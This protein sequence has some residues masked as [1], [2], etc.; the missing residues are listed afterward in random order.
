MNCKHVQFL[1]V[2]IA[3]A[4]LSSTVIAQQYSAFKIYIMSD[5]PRIDSLLFGNH[6]NATY[7]LDT[8]PL[9]FDRDT[10]YEGIVPLPPPGC[11]SHQSWQDLPWYPARAGGDDLLYIDFR[12]YASPTQSDT[13][14]MYFQTD[15]TW[16]ITIKWPSAAYL[17][18]RCDS[19]FFRIPDLELKLDMFSVDHYTFDYGGEF[20][21]INKI[22][23]AYIDKYGVRL[24]KSVKQENSAVPSSFALH[25]NYPNP[26]NPT[27]TIR[28]EIEKRA[29][30]DI[31][32]YNMLGQ[33]VATLHS[34]ELAPGTYS[35]VWDGL[36]SQGRPMSSGVYYVRMN[37]KSKDDAQEFNALK[38][39][40]LLK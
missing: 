36:N 7:G 39:L 11:G 12:G 10:L 28:F 31:S 17:A 25:Q 26:F 14:R 15:S 18:E 16:K 5:E 6:I 40:L 35:V 22:T 30:T 1:F 9:V 37:A 2:I 32:I 4:L 8:S 3:V 19:M 24:I 38:K 34:Q 13:F 21:C 23:F 29:K 27:T 20:L 33:K